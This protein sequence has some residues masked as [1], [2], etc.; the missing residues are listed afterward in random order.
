MT[1]PTVGPRPQ[2]HEARP[3]HF[4]RPQVQPLAN[5]MQVWAFQLPGQHVLSVQLVMDIA[6]ADEPPGLDGVATLALRGSD[7]GSR[8]HPGF[9]LARRIEDIGAAYD[10]NAGWWG[11]A[12]GISVAAPQARDGLQLLHEIVRE[13][14]YAPDDIERHRAI[15]LAEIERSRLNSAVLAGAAVR[16]AM[17]PTASRQALAAGGSASGIEAS[18]EHAI[19]EFHDRWWRPEGATLVLAGDLPEGL[20]Q[21]ACE[22]FGAWPA[23]G[24]RP[25]RTAPEGHGGSPTI[26]VVDRPGAVAADLQIGLIT[27]GR[28]HPDW[29]RMQVAT[30][31]LGG[32]FGSRLNLVLREQRGYTYG[33]QAGLHAGRFNGTFS[34]RSSFRTEV[35]ARACREVVNLLDVAAQPLDEHETGDAVRYLSGIAPLRYDTAEAI[36]EQASV[37]AAHQVSPGWIDELH[38]RIASTSAEQASAAFARHIGTAVARGGAHIA[39]CGDAATLAP[40]LES[41]GFGVELVTPTL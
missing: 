34:V 26:R 29:A 12:A 2:V 5:G 25:D 36:A 38:A 31:C 23:T 11:T 37:L 15:R 24:L 10:G 4:P 9:E 20:T 1:M 19:H 7:E 35:A 41:Q 21:A 33:V 22:L 18:D 13:P 16:E 8:T 40:Q 30:M 39:L 28:Q 3:W 17:W 6:L 27:P 32:L 14:L